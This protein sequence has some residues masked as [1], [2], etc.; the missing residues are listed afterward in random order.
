MFRVVPHL[1]LALALMACDRDPEQP[2][3]GPW[4]PCNE[5]KRCSDDTM[6]CEQ[7]WAASDVTY[8]APTCMWGAACEAPPLSE[9]GIAVAARCTAREDSPVGSCVADCTTEDDCPAGTLCFFD[10]RYTPSTGQG[11]CAWPP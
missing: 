9:A 5:G 10:D 4:Q 7:A 8:C 6:I 11:I 1:A 2:R 3:G